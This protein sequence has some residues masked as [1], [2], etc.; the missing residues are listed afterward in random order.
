MKIGEVAASASQTF[1]LPH[2]PQFVGIK[3]G[4]GAVLKNV[5]V[6]VND[7]Q[8]G[9]IT[10]L[11]GVS[12][13]QVGQTMKSSSVDLTTDVY[14][15]PCAVGRIAGVTT[16]VQVSMDAGG[17]A[18]VYEMS[19]V[20]SREKLFMESRQVKILGNN[21]TSFN[22]F[23][24]LG[25]QDMA[26]GDYLVRVFGNGGQSRQEFEEVYSTASFSFNN[27]ADYAVVD[28]MQKGVSQVDVTPVADRKAWIVAAKLNGK[29]TMPNASVRGDR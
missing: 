25:I 7:D 3:L 5:T 21:T 9:T 11:D 18:E 29:T 15:V 1:V 13:R 4:A 17:T 22:K 26:A 27:S 28:N 19:M 16:N 8:G 23:F 24:L 12:F 20:A 10:Q 6:T 14:Y 2:C